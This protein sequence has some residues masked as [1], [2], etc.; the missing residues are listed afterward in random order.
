MLVQD[1]GA[2]Y[3]ARTDQLPVLGSL[4]LGYAVSIYVTFEMDV[5]AAYLCNS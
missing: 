2:R 3:Q 1:F 5:V 4:R